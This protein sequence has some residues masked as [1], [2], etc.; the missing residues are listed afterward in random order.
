MPHFRCVAGKTRLY[1]AA[2]PAD[3]VG[4]LCPGCGSLLEPVGKLAEVVGFRSIRS[5]AS[6]ADGGA[7]GTHQ[8]IAHR[9]GDFI[10]R[11]DVILAGAR[12]DAR[13][14]VDDDAATH[15]HPPDWRHSHEHSLPIPGYDRLDNKQVTDQLS[16]LGSPPSSRLAPAPALAGTWMSLARTS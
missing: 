13:R 9:F 16:R 5:R 2:D 15:S 4:D 7:P 12:L 11:R 8:R 6:P 3:L 10:A 14:W 1:S